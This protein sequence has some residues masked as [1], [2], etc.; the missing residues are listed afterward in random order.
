MRHK[1]L[2]S[3]IVV[4]LA[5]GLDHRL[6]AERGAELCPQ[7]RTYLGRGIPT[8]CDNPTANSFTVARHLLCAVPKPEGNIGTSTGN[9]GSNGKAGGLK[10]KRGD[11]SSDNKGDEANGS[12]AAADLYKREMPFPPSHYALS[13]ADMADMEYP[14]PKLSK[15]GDLVVGDGFVV[16]QPAGGG[17]ARK[18]HID[19]VAV[20]CEMCYTSEGLE[21]TRVSA[22]GP[23]GEVIYDK[24]VM[25]PR[26]ITDYNTDYSGITA[27]QMEGVTTT[28]EDVQKELLELIPAETILIGHSLENDLR[29]LKMMHANVVDTVALYPHQHRVRRKRLPH[30]PYTPIHGF[31][32]LIPRVCLSPLPF[33]DSCIPVSSLCPC[34]PFRTRDSRRFL[35]PLSLCRLHRPL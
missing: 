28:L 21:L 27:E 10:R 30:F 3:T 34:S 15:D 33:S 7:L 26:E 19:L 4:L 6:Y 17:I 11:G 23:T 9:N 16:T 1:P 5:P 12:T 18:E 25:P 8:V 13:A 22:V 20:D 14:I 29:R 2:C 24:L 32:C 35:S 31:Y